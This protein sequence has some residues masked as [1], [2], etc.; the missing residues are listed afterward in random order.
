MTPRKITL[1]ALMLAILI[2]C[3]Q[4]AIPLGLVPITLQTFAVLIIGLLLPPKHASTTMLIYL[5]IGLVGLPVFSG[6][7]GGLGSFLSPSFGFAIAFIPTTYFLSSFVRK[8]NVE[9]TSTLFVAVSLST[10]ILYTI[11]LLYMFIIFTKVL[12]IETGFT[13]LLQVGMIPFIPGD[14]LK[15]VLAIFIYKRLKP[16]LSF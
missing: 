10:V 3:S 4:L 11:G 12:E 9:K 15:S 16:R 1:M 6:G 5:V 14:I 7:S 2:I 13:H 8:Y